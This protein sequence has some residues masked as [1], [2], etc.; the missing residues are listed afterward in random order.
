MRRHPRTRP[1]AALLAMASLLLAGCGL[2]GSDEL[3][4]T[5]EFTDVQDL[6]TN[7]H[8]RAGDV[9]IGTVRGIELTDDGLARVTMSIEPGTGLPAETEAVLSKTG[10]LGERFIDLR[11]IGDSGQLED[12]QHLTQTRIITDFEDLV[13]TSN[14]LLAFLSADR[15]AVMVETGA[16]ALGD[17]GGVLGEFIESVNGFVGEVEQ[18][19]Q[20]LLDLIDATDQLTST[21]A[22]SAQSNAEA[23]AALRRA[24]EALGDEDDRLLDTLDDVTRLSRVGTRLLRETRDETDATVR[25]LRKFVEQLTRI[26]GALQGTLT[27]LPRHNL[28]VPNGAIRERAQVWLDFIVCGEND[29]EGD[30]SRDC[31]P[32][33]PNES[34][35]SPGFAPNP[36]SCDES[37]TDCPN[38]PPSDD[39]GNGDD[40]GGQRSSSTTGS[41]SATGGPR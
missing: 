18:D 17:R 29:T 31:T 13:A 34:S 3:T 7:A 12:G 21:L 23:L 37:H 1:I 28:H 38:R 40:D 30:P 25:Q 14:D 22:G 24:S 26:E 19:Q 27:W 35:E 15:L 16:V 41:H 8:V 33:N 32:P 36:D 11:P 9:P 10:L 20:V 5:A 4:L 39:D 6:V 2:T